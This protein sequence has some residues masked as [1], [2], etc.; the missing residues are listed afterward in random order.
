M[1]SRRSTADLPHLFPSA[2]LNP[3]QFWHWLLKFWTVSVFQY[4]ILVIFI[5]CCIVSSSLWWLRMVI[6]HLWGA[7]MMTF[8]IKSLSLSIFINM[9]VDC[10]PKRNDSVA[11]L[12]TLFHLACNLF[13][14]CADKCRWIP[15]AS[16]LLPVL[17]PG[18][19][20]YSFY[21]INHL[22]PEQS[23]Y[24]HCKLCC[25]YNIIISNC[26]PLLMTLSHHYIILVMGTSYRLT[27]Y[28]INETKF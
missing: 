10:Q 9:Y 27:E 2:V 1:C 6:V 19:W 7:T 24:S 12:C 15:P 20:I 25:S 13:S 23:I 16:S 14:N 26:A 3:L 11:V 4:N 5:P 17:D 22:I 8:C 18:C 28:L 21:H